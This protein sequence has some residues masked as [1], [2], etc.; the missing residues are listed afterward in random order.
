MN[1]GEKRLDAK[2]KWKLL[3]CTFLTELKKDF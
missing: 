3:P 2:I 1:E